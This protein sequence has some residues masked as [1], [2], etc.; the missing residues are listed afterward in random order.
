MN[1]SG[2]RAA[3][4]INLDEFER[5][6]R[7]AGAQQASVEDPLAGTGPPGRIL[8][9]RDLEGETSARRV[10]GTGQ[11]TRGIRPVD[12]NRGAAAIDRRRRKTSFLRRRR[13]IARRGKIMSSTPI[14]PT[15]PKTAEPG[16]RSA[17]EALEAHGFRAGARGRGDDR[18]GVRAQGPGPRPAEGASV[19]RGGSGTDQGAAAKRRDGYRLQ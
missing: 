15:T 8:T 10:A 2:S 4:D 9:L 7:A 1:V 12:R 6:L 14:A 5:R 16:R 13:P 11:E 19:H 17:T 3:D 18:R